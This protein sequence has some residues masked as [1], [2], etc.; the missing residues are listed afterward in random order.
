MRFPG[1][2]RRQS[3]GQSDQVTWYTNVGT[4]GMDY[5]HDIVATEDGGF[6]IAGYT[7]HYPAV[8]RDVFIARADGGGS[9]IWQNRIAGD[10]YEYA[11]CRDT[12]F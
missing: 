12:D 5:A 4:A 8:S 11:E 9:V 2:Q 3:D 6:V 1:V 7:E 10:Y